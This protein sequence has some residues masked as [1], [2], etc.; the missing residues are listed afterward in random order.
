MASLYELTGK[1]LE[2]MY[3]LED[4]EIPD[5]VI[6]DTL[7]SS[8]ESMDIDYK[9]D[10]YGRIIRNL[11]NEIIGIESEL[12]RLEKRKTTFQNR[13]KSL[14]NNLKTTMEITGK[15]RITT[16]L[17]TF[18]IQKNGGKRKLDLSVPITDLPE[19]FRIKQPDKVDGDALREFISS[20][21]ETKDDG[22]IVSEYGVIQPQGESLRIK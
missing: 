3:M 10:C 13:I 11:E 2:L 15:K 19:K 1:Y 21:G 8:E 22:S 6:Q 16:D 9:A 17:F 4:M 5:D 14:K 20:H 7:E 12:D 18:N